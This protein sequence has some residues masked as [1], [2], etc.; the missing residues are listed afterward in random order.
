MKNAVVYLVRASDKDVSEFIQSIESIKRF[1][2]EKNEVDI[3]CFHEEDLC[4]HINKIN[5]QVKVN[6]KY[7]QIKFQIPDINK[8]LNIPEFYPHPT[9]GNG[10]IAYGHPGFTLGYRH[11]CRFFA[12]EIFRNDILNDYNY[13]M[14]MDTD[15]KVLRQ[16][17]Y[18]VFDYMSTNDLYYGFIANAVQ[19]DN[20]KVCIGLWAKSL[21]WSNSNKEACLKEPLKEIEEY[22]LYYTNFE[23]CKLEWFKKSKYLD[24]FDYIDSAGGIYTNRWGDHVIRYIGV[25][26]LMEDNHKYPIYDIAYQHGAIYNS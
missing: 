8:H 23:I 2:I 7:V 6:L 4:P 5:G 12:G 18:N 13:I 10:P 9:H 20:P 11:M 14:R 1:F 3:I 21:E 16:V 17:D 24:F 26:M 15:S 25:N 22:K 19:L